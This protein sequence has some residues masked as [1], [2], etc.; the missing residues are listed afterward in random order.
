MTRNKHRLS[1][2]VLVAIALALGAVG[3]GDGSVAVSKQG[4]ASKERLDE[5]RRET[6]PLREAKLNIEHN[7]TDGDTGFQGFIDSEG[8]QR[9]DVKGPDGIVLSLQGLGKLG[10][11]GLTEL[12][13]ESVE[14]E[15]ADVPI[16][17]ILDTLPEGNY[18]IEGRAMESGESAGRTSGTAWLTHTIPA[19]PDLL[20][21]AAG[22]TVPVTGLV[23]S[24][25][26]VTVSGT[27]R[28][29]AS[30]CR[31]LRLR[32]PPTCMASRARGIRWEWQCSSPMP[33]RRC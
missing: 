31:S 6:V 8:W 12:F 22:A 10:R 26:R 9:L 29:R 3:W 16:E 30:G 11:L 13:F 20:S 4:P 24:W 33:A 17:E 15:N 23:A 5:A 28:R 21:P 25:R 19:G 2:L 1:V 18:T 7:A 27:H 32:V 14:P